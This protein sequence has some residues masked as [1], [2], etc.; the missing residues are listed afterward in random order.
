MP[1]PDPKDQDDQAYNERDANL[2]HLI[3]KKDQRLPEQLM[4]E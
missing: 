1:D 4:D 2:L 3:E